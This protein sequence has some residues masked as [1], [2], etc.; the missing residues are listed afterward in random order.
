VLEV[1][2]Y[3]ITITTFQLAVGTV[4][5]LFMWGA[6]LYRRPVLVAILP[7][8][9]IHTFGNLFT[10]MSLG[11]VAVSFTHTIK[12]LEPFFTIVLSALFLG[13]VP[14]VWVL[15]SLVPIVGGVAL[16]SFTEASFNWLVLIFQLTSITSGNHSYKLVA[17]LSKQDWILECHG[18]E[19]GQSIM[20]CVEQKVM[21]KK[22]VLT[23]LRYELFDFSMQISVVDN[24]PNYTVNSWL[25]ISHLKS[26]FEQES[27][28]NINL[29]SI[30][31][32]MSLFLTIPVMLLAEGIKFTPSYMHS[33]GL[34]LREIFTRSLLAGLCFHA[35]QQVRFSSLH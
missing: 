22:E 12:A 14:T 33:A 19:P 1:Y 2:P 4:L 18:F 32:I 9:I 11:K 30:I 6:K 34:N 13:E 27:L 25:D 3:P 20:K 26:A 8:A 5:I 23:N 16:A 7:L 15:A 31:T 10:N 17:Y 29:F 35:Y 21:G 28:D 24:L